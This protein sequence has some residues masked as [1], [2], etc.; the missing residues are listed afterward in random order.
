MARPES[1]SGP[2]LWLGGALLAAGAAVLGGY[3]VYALTQAEE[4]PAL[5]ML[6]LLALP[7]GMAIVLVAAIRDRIKHKK[8]ENFL[9]VDN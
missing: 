3:W 6:A 7:A 2:L 9:E 8:R 4:M 1:S 5:L